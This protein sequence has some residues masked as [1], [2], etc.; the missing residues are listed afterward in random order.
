M[1]LRLLATLTLGACLFT[2]PALAAKAPQKPPV[3]APKPAEP[4]VTGLVIDARDLDF[5]P[6]M[7]PHLF[8]DG[9]HNLL[10]GLSFDPEQVTNDGFARWVRSYDP[11]ARNPRVGAKPMLLKPVRA[12]GDRLVFSAE[13]A[14]KLKAA[15]VKDRFL[16][17]M[18]ILIVY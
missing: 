15:N 4:D 10:E 13:D 1:R 17:R 7:S 18:R 16:D 11:A 14:A 2:L 9:A 3:V 6:C 8:D 5:E 12:E